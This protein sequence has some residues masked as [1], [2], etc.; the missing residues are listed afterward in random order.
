MRPP[1]VDTSVWYALVDARDVNHEQAVSL[2]ARPRQAVITTNVVFAESLTLARKRLGHDSAVGL[3]RRL[4][5]GRG[6]RLLRVESSDEKQAWQIFQ[7]SHDKDFS[8]TD[9]TSFA[10]MRRL[11]LAHAFAFDRHFQQMGFRV[12]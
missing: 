9:C 4:L 11:R 12:N 5:D 10:V 2:M 1:F 3:G 6:V 8:F 7:R